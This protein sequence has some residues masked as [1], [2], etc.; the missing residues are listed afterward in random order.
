MPKKIKAFNK[1]FTYL[2]QSG[3]MTYFND[4]NGDYLFSDNYDWENNLN[5]EVEIIEEDKKIEKL[6]FNDT[7]VCCVDG[8]MKQSLNIKKTINEIIDVINELKKGE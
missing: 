1:T 8:L 6:T 4:D 7:D 5:M 3:D 2:Y